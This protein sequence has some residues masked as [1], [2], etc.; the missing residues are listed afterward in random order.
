[1]LNFVQNS[2]SDHSVTHALCHFLFVRRS[3]QQGISLI[4]IVLVI[5]IAS[6]VLFAVAQV[7]TLSLRI[8]AEKKIE[9]KATYY[10]QEGLEALH[11]MR[12][13]SWTTRI[14]PLSASTT[15]YVAPTASAWTLS[16]TNPGALDGV[17][18]RTVVMRDVARDA[19]DDIVSAGGTN[20]PDTKKF[21]V[22]VTWNTP[23]GT[24]L[25]DSE[26]Y[27]VNM[28]GN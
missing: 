6:T 15:Y 10:M 20:D 26:T 5:F 22:T 19:G 13:E 27:L 12:D 2:T 3:S 14:A 9:L 11:A 4:E 23:A 8:S 21:T 25:V 28:Y 18:T 17:Y 16:G 24:R 7:A 1:M